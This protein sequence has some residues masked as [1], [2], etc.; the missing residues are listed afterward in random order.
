M[1]LKDIKIE[2]AKLLIGLSVIKTDKAVLSYNGEDL[3]AGMEVWIDEN[4]E[5]TSVE[6]GDYTTED[7]R[8]ITVKDG[9]V[10]SIVDTNAEID[11]ESEITENVIENAEEDST[12]VENVET[13]DTP[14]QAE[15][16]P[17]QG[18]DTQT[19]I[20]KLREEVNELYKI[21]DTLLKKLEIT[22]EEADERF[23][24]LECMSI[25]KPAT[26]EFEQPT[27]R[28]TGDAKLDKFLSK[29]GNN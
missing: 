28:K 6:D 16:E 15:E 1:L 7:G 18:E 27:S 21:V 5:K 25:A 20:D 9:K 29:F 23:K 26:E 8:V 3:V 14:V 19:A 12:E 24:K 2:L 10:I 4:D 22:R 11:A 13:E 17:V